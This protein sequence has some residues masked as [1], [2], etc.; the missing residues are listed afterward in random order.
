MTN[1]D[2]E[3]INEK[4]EFFMEEQI[5][6]HV[7]LVDKTFLNGY[8]MKKVRDGCYWFQDKKL[9]GVYLFSKDIYEVK[10]YTE[11]VGK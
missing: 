4:L 7:K 3:R 2:E 6:V 5:K 9:N 1:D 8:I 10:E 11:G